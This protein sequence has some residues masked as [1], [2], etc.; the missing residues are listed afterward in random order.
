MVDS[1]EATAF[2]RCFSVLQIGLQD[3][4]SEITPKLFS[5]GL[6][7][8]GNQRK[9]VGN[10]PCD[11]PRAL[12]LVTV[13]L[14]RIRVDSSS[15]YRILK[16]FEAC[17]VLD[18]LAKRLSEELNRIKREA[19]EPQAS[20][21]SV[22]RDDQ[23]AQPSAQVSQIGQSRSCEPLPISLSLLCS[24]FWEIPPKSTHYS[25][26]SILLF[27]NYS[28]PHIYMP[29]RNYS[30]YIRLLKHSSCYFSRLLESA[31]QQQQ[32]IAKLLVVAIILL[33]NSP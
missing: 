15:F 27:S 22:H 19:A 14:D 1:C 32:K 26:K 24:C 12:H 10:D 31:Q 13:L 16:E 20:T 25:H 29:S 3:H 7:S 17:P 11:V 30:M 5:E 18:R 9:I 33:G 8:N 21:A 2:T 4:L 28:H 23:R 6:V